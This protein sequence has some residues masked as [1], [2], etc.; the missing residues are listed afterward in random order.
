MGPNKVVHLMFLSGGL[1]LFFLLT[2]T[3]DWIWGYFARH[4]NEFIIQGGAVLAALTA[5]IALYRN[6]HVYGLACDVAGE[7]KK[8]SWPTRKET[9][10]AT[11]VVIVTVILAAIILGIF[12]AI[13]SELTDIVYG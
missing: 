3:G 9:Q 11:L 10:A 12:D 7:L 6:D 4:P 2:W 5:G 13:W 8:V 1:L